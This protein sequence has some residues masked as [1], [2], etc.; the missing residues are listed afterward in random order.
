MNRVIEQ[1]KPRLRDPGVSKSVIGAIKV[2][3]FRLDDQNSLRFLTEEYMKH[4]D[5]GFYLLRHKASSTVE[6]WVHAEFI[7]IDELI[8]SNGEVV[9]LKQRNDEIEQVVIRQ[10]NK[11]EIDF[12]LSL[13]DVII[14]KKLPIGMFTD[15]GQLC[16]SKVYAMW[17][18]FNFH[19]RGNANYPFILVSFD[20]GSETPYEVKS[21]GLNFED[22]S[23]NFKTFNELTEHLAIYKGEAVEK[24]RLEWANLDRFIEEID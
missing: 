20:V 16:A 24:A 5:V 10:R 6:L 13:K 2:G 7:D 22:I 11:R 3:E 17:G 8:R 18:E 9:R 1:N 14:F 19:Y 21:E 4:L 15:I 23:N 12:Y